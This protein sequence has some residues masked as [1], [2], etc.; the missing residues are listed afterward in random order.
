MKAKPTPTK[1]EVE[2]YH[3]SNGPLWFGLLAGPIAWIIHLQTS[4]S[5]VIWVCKSGHEMALHILSLC[6]LLLAIGGALVAWAQFNAC[7]LTPAARSRDEGLIARS[8]F[9]ALMG[10]MN[11]V[12]FALIIIAQGIPSFIISPCVN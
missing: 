2:G 11:S 8:R 12:L 3:Q 7:E 10:M 4:Y 1:A 6:C 9:M 5:L